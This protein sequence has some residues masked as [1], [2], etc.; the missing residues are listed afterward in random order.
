MN[1]NLIKRER[2]SPVPGGG[3][4]PSF[5]PLPFPLDRLNYFYGQLLGVR[6]FQDEQRYFHE[7]NKLHNRFMH[8]H[9]VVCGL[10]VKPYRPGTTGVPMPPAPQ[11]PPQ[12]AAAVG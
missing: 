11:A 1:I 4:T 8:G 9:G 3:A 6:D 2:P 12:S 10:E 5:S 7:K